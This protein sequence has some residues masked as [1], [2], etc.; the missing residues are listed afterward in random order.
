MIIFILINIAVVML[1]IG[2]DLYRHHF[3][4]LKFSSILLAISINSVIDIF[5]IDKFNFITLFTIILFTVWAILQIYLDIKLYPFIITEQKFIGAIFAILISIAQFI[6]DSSSTQS[7]YMSIPY[8]SPAI[9]ILGAILVFIGTFNIAEV[10]R[11]SLLR[12]IKRPIT[13]GSIIIILSL[14]L[15][16]ILT[17]FWY[18]F[19]IIYFLFI[20]FILWQG[21]FFVKNK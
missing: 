14:I 18:V 8:L 21:I 20:A 5:V 4:Q 1:I 19:V 11:L 7:V 6:T 13:T 17:P 12:K 3:K 15:M 2:L 16:M 10:E 9:F